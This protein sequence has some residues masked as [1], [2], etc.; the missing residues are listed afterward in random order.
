[1]MDQHHTYTGFNAGHFG[2]QGDLS[3]LDRRIAELTEL[4][5]EVCELAA[6][7][8]DVVAACQLLP[9]RMGRLKTVLSSHQ[10]RYTL[11]APIAVNLM[12]E[13]HLALQIRAAEAS[14]ELAAEC[15]ADVV[16]FHPG[17]VHPAQWADKFRGLLKREQET[18]SRLADRADTLGVRIAYENMSPNRRIIAGTETSYALDLI[19]LADQIAAVD[20]PALVACLDVNHAQQG[21]VLQGYDLYDQIAKLAPY[22]GHIHFSD[23][24][25]LPSTIQWDND[26]ERLFFGIGDMHAPPGF[27]VI[28]FAEMA[29]QLTV[30]PGTA[31]V[32]E[33]K[34]NHF[35][36]S[37][38]MTIE[39][40]RNFAAA[41]GNER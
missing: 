16:V 21:R 11:H 27:G 34:E 28:D 26:G 5:A 3:A 32:I 7:R 19:A 38:R 20:H 22:V 8:L 29:R 37:A 12:D 2:P 23:S 40:A 14:L 25:G 39:A 13:A 33:L 17:R 4:G 6:V 30:L 9:E 24:T 10:I 41:I 35:R 31:I 18:L 36:H 15:S 1:M